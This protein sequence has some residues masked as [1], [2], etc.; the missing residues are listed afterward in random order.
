MREPKELLI[1]ASTFTLSSDRL[2]EFPRCA[3]DTERPDGIGAEAGEWVDKPGENE[4]VAIGAG[5]TLGACSR[6]ESASNRSPI[7]PF[8][9]GGFTQAALSTDDIL[10]NV[11]ST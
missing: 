4:E 1:A 7:S 3:D 8:F 2:E 11:H 9:Q 10:C 5:E 6:S